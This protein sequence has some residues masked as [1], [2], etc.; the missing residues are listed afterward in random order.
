[1]IDPAEK[2]ILAARAA[3]RGGEFAVGKCA[4]QCDES[5]DRPEGEQRESVRRFLHLQSERGEDAGADDI[6]DDGG[7]CGG[8][9]EGAAGWRHGH[10]MAIMKLSSRPLLLHANRD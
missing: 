4:R 10:E 2:T 8:K 1:M 9:A 3:N 7:E 6:G 5:A